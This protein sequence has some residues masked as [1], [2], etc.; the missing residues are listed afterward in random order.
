MSNAV[1]IK[2]RK[3]KRNPLLARKQV[4]PLVLVRWQRWSRKCGISY[5]HVLPATADLSPVVITFLLAPSVNYDVCFWNV[6]CFPH[7]F[8]LSVDDY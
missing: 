1:I 5:D 3:F 8:V 6:E 2:T 4:G 7:A